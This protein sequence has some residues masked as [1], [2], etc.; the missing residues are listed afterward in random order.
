VAAFTLGGVVSYLTTYE[1]GEAFPARSVH[2]TV[3]L[4]PLVSGPP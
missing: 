2:V 3:V 4:A 1:P